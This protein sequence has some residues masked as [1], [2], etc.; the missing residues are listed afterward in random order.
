MLPLLLL[1]QS[2]LEGS[3]LLGTSTYMG[4]LGK[5]SG[6]EMADH[7][8]SAGLALRRYLGNTTALRANLLYGRL[9]GTDQDYADRERRGYSFKTTLVECSVVGEWEPFA[10]DRSV[11]GVEGN[12]ARVSPYLFLGVG[13]AFIN[14]EVDFNGQL[15]NLEQARLDDQAAYS[16]VQLVIPFGAGL[17]VGVN[18]RW[19]LGLEAGLRNPFTDYLDGVSEAGNP[20]ENDWYFIGGLSLNYRIK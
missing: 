4:D 17:R 2:N 7:N 20:D 5:S 9:S 6:L 10:P 13:A 19:S 3:L 12:P 1:A 16:N 8:F 14:P 18:E 15:D 11:T